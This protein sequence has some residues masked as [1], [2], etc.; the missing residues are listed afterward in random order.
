[1]AIDFPLSSSASLLLT[2]NIHEV[3]RVIDIHWATAEADDIK[4]VMLA[5]G[6]SPHTCT[7]AAGLCATTAYV[8]DAR[9][10]GALVYT[11]LWRI[12]DWPT[13]SPKK[14]RNFS[15]PR[16]SRPGSF[17]SA[18]PLFDAS[19][20]IQWGCNND[21]THL[22]N[23]YLCDGFSLRSRAGNPKMHIHGSRRRGRV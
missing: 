13:L 18:T 23:A 14:R 7:V 10:T 4:C 9:C 11:S 8:H 1:M 19:M 2:T 16:I 5:R 6:A 15:F 22:I 21:F 3:I 12:D 17:L 20:T